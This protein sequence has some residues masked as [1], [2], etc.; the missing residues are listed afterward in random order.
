[1]RNSLARSI[2]ALLLALQ[3]LSPGFVYSQQEVRQ[4]RTRAPEEPPKTSS[5]TASGEWQPPTTG[6]IVNLDQPTADSAAKQEP[7]IRVA[8]AT[9]VRSATIST[10]GHLMNATDLA[11]TLV[12][13]DVAR[14]RVEPRLLSPLPAS[15]NVDAYRIQIAGLT[16]RADAEEKSRAIREATSEGSQVAYD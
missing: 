2:I 1:M 15:D 6:T 14:V 5:Q 16:S 10:S 13:M 4:R 12:A 8:L 11:T 3:V 9:D 7:T